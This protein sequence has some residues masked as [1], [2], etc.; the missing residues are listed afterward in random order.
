MF[1]DPRVRVKKNNLKIWN[2]NEEE[3]IQD[4]LAVVMK[5]NIEE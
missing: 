5:A 4:D 3:N 1:P 2:Y